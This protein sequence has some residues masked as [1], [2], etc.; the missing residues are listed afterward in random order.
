MVWI[1]L[2]SPLFN[3]PCNTSRTCRPSSFEVRKQELPFMIVS[4]ISE[5]PRPRSFPEYRLP[6]RRFSN[7]SGALKSIMLGRNRT[8]PPNQFGSVRYSMPLV[9]SMIKF[10]CSFVFESPLRWMLPV[11]PLFI[12]RIADTSLSFGESNHCPYSGLSGRMFLCFR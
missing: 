10:A 2:S 8:V 7:A 4:A 3:I 12:R 1:D 6:G 5:G 11:I 9:P